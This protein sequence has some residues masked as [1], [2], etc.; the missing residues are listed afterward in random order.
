MTKTEFITGLKKAYGSFER[1]V[2]KFVYTDFYLILVCAVTLIGWACPSAPFGFTAAVVIACV[3][4]LAIDD[5]LPLTVNLFSAVLLVYSTDFKDYT[6]LWPLVFP[7]AAC[8]IVFMVKNAKRELHLGKMFFPLMAVAY[9]LLL[10][11]LGYADRVSFLKALPDFFLLGVGVPAAYLFYA[12]YLKRDDKRDI[13]LYFSKTLM[14]IGLVIS[15]QLVSVIAKSG[16]PVSEWHYTTWELGWA[17]RNG[18]ATYLI[19][20]AGMTVYL[21]TR[22]R[23]G[24][25]FL[26]FGLFQYACLILTF[27]RGGIIFG[28]L[29]G[30]LAAVFS[31]IKAPNKKL[32]LLYILAI[33]I[34]CLVIY[35]ALRRDI[36]AMLNALIDRGTG[37]SGR[38]DLYKEAWG[39]FK[40]H[41]LFGVGRGY[42]GYGDGT[43]KIGIYRFHSTIF[44]VIAC[45]GVVGLAAYVYYYFVRL[46]ILFVNIKNCFNLFVLAV[47]IGFEGYSLIDTGTFIGYP[48][49]ALV[50]V[51]T[52][53]LERTQTDFCGYVTPYNCSTRLGAR[54][55]AAGG[56]RAFKGIRLLNANK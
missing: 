8:L 19:F 47:W 53:L 36:N 2:K 54:I 11:G 37:S 15:I 27:S 12:N 43:S 55:A 23:Q 18:I 33:A 35:F 52:L 40:A 31:L 3:A 56:V 51:M 22:Y 49:M 1:I 16:I 7:L 39:L 30:I 6:Y 10:G 20:T 41:P 29:S 5:A 44:Q 14:Y 32:H 45:M 42:V 50:I 9:V 46:K 4:I 25:I 34:A 48:Y 28:V 38:I 21:S 24:W 17:N 13:P 26:A